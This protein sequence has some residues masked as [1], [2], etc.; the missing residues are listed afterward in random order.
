MKLDRV[1]IT[2]IDE[3]TDPAALGNLHDEFPFV[4][5]AVLLSESRQ[6]IEPRYPSA[7]YQ[8][9]LFTESFA[10]MAG[11]L[12]GQWARDAADGMF[13]WAIEHSHMFKM[14]DRIQFNLKPVDRGQMSRRCVR[15]SQAYPSKGFI[16]Q[17]EDFDQARYS[18]DPGLPALLLDQSGGRGV[19]LTDFP[20]PIV[21]RYCGYAGGFG[22]DNLDA[23]L[24]RLTA[25]PGDARFWVDMESNVRTGDWLDLDKVRACL[26][27]A[28]RYA[29]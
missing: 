21:G 10:P 18:D 17:A 19:E 23:A 24:K 8:H 16:V 13:L 5:F 4:E 25:L 2:G 9:R 7:D 15:L 3:R 20:L 14:F 29:R 26:E 12:C 6:G 22:P 1:T 11:H 28:A 27:I